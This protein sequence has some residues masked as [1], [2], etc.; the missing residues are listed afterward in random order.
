MK[1]KKIAAFLIAVML[2]TASITGGSAVGLMTGVEAQE[3]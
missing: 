1:R 3:V 2:G